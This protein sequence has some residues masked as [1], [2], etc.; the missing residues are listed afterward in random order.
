MVYKNN[1]FNSFPLIGYGRLAGDTYSDDIW[2]CGIL[3][4]RVDLL[5][6]AT[7]RNAQAPFPPRRSIISRRTVPPACT[8]HTKGPEKDLG[9]ENLYMW[10]DI[11]W[12][13]PW[14]MF[15]EFVIWDGICPMLSEI[16]EIQQ[17]SCTEIGEERK[18]SE[19]KEY[20]Q[21]SVR[22]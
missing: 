18:E 5:T 17:N 20:Q 1:F 13:S 6:C 22:T 9:W 16:N 21:E 19:W 2:F 3:L 14:E 12:L 11:Q 8:R 4:L 10:F 7:D 15:C